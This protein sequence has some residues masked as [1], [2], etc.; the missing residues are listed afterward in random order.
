MA[1]P[2]LAAVLVVAALGAAAAPVF[3]INYGIDLGT[4]SLASTP[5]GK[6]QHTLARSFT[7]GILA[8]IEVVVT[9]APSE[10]PRL[11]GALS[12]D[13]RVARLT[14]QP[15]DGATLLRVIPSVP[16]DSQAA[17]DLVGH[18]RS[19]LTPAVA[20][21][22]GRVLVGGATAEFVDFAHRTRARFSWVLAIVLATALAFLLAVFRSVVL[23][24]KA[25]A[26]NLLATGASL[27]LLVLVFQYGYGRS[28]LGFTST[29][30]IQVYIPVIVFVL[31]FGLSMDYEVFLIS[32][33]RETWLATRD[34]TTA[35]ADGIAHTARP[36]T[37]AAA[38][39]V[40]VFGSFLIAG[41][42]ELKQ[43]GFGLAV[44]IA[45]DATLV[46]LVLVPALMRLLGRYNW[47]L[48]RPPRRR[49]HA[50]RV[51]RAG[52]G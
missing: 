11:A 15:G 4:S 8:P 7:P 40:A 29:G 9:R 33:M 46:R 6:A 51:R 37:A 42:L 50:P 32:R 30:F 14:R 17:T 13:P 47:W 5:A 28:L 26:M 43:F 12:S 49:R 10:V 25:V 48:P 22:G 44:A 36:I 52:T 27:G 1:R 21:D 16:I 2:I 20:T 19:D 23:P 38:I 34:N 3:G 45:L 31:L 35:V 24:L 41:V 18:I 39:M